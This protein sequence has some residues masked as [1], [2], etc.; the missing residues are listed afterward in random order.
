[1]VNQKQVNMVLS[2]LQLSAAET[3]SP[4]LLG[5]MCHQWAGYAFS[6]SSV[7]R[8]M[9]RRQSMEELW[10]MKHKA[11]I[12]HTFYIENKFPP[13]SYCRDT[14][15]LRIWN[16][17]S[18]ALGSQGVLW[19]Y[20][21]FGKRSTCKRQDNKYHCFCK[22]NPM[23]NTGKVTANRSCLH[24]A[25]SPKLDL[26]LP[27]SLDWKIFMWRNGNFRIYWSIW[28]GRTTVTHRC[29]CQV[30]EFKPHRTLHH[31][32]FSLSK[33]GISGLWKA[34]GMADQA[35]LFSSVISRAPSPDFAGLPDNCQ[36]IYIK[37]LF[38][39][40]FSNV[41]EKEWISQSARLT[42]SKYLQGRQWSVPLLLT[43]F[44]WLDLTV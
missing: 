27:N 41:I 11:I 8:I 3:I 1:M 4:G 33:V 17:P 15:T 40:S 37:F 16:I 12:K 6:V 29:F 38:Y 25:H 10:C 31:L 19:P 7:F 13:V 44:V 35:S 34:K 43:S 28:E 26:S 32:E 22:R 36:F 18:T 30:S 2:Y 9:T 5:L 20:K 39:F 24:S 42:D 21:I 14:E 23:L